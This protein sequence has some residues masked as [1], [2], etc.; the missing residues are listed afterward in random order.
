MPGFP[1]FLCHWQRRLG[2]RILPSKI[3][4]N[5]LP[6][7]AASAQAAFLGRILP[8]PPRLP[9]ATGSGGSAFE[10]FHQIYQSTSS[11]GTLLLAQAAFPGR[12]LPGPLR[13][14]LPLAA[15]ARPSNPSIK[16]TNQ[17]APPERSLSAGSLPWEDSSRASPPSSCHWQ[18]R[19][20]LRI[21]P[22]NLPINKLPRNT[23][24]GASGLSREDSSRASPPSSATGSGGAAF[25]SVHQ[26]YQ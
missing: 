21:L 26:K 9:P 7:N 18:R 3:P 22:S 1:A 19:L 10:S 6:R 11:P 14:P 2:L 23:A 24:L 12:I 4:I 17:Q 8:G 20:G 16:N 5:K 13:L 15:A 25:E